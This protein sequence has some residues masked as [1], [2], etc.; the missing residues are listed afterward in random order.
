MT[1]WTVGVGLP[2]APV[3]API[4]RSFVMLIALGVGILGAGIVLAAY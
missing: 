2:S 1:G 3:D 4:R